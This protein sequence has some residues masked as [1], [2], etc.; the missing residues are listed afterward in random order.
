M[1]YKVFSKPECSMCRKVK[2][3]ILSAGH[4]I[5]A[6]TAEYHSLPK[7]G[8]RDRDID[9]AGFMGMLSRQ[10]QALPV[11]FKKDG[12]GWEYVPIEEALKC[13]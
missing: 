5:E 1:I 9:F 12:N 7:E 2:R 10:N 8:W 11:V 13:G 3:A 4:D 6:H